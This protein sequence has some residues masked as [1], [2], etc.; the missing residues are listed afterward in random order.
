MQR[1]VYDINL[2]ELTFD[3]LRAEQPPHCNV[4]LKPH[5][6]T[7]LQRC[8]QYER[9]N[10][11]LSEFETM[12][13]NNIPHDDYIRTQIG[14]LGDRVGSGKSFV[15]LALLMSPE[16]VQTGSVIKSYGLNKVL[17]STRDI[18]KPVRTN[19]LVIPHNLC[20]QWEQYINR[21]SS[22]LSYLIIN[23]NA[24]LRQLHTLNY[25][26]YDLLVITGTQYNSAAQIIATKSIKVKRAIFDEVDSINI[27]SCHPIEASFY[28]FVT[29]S[30]GNLLYPRGHSR[31][32]TANGQTIMNATGLKNAGFIKNLFTDLNNNVSKDY[33]KVLVI[34][35]R[36]DFVMQSIQLEDAMSHEIMCK[37]PHAIRVLHGLVDKKIINCLNAGDVD[38]AISCINPHHRTT[39]DNIITLLVNK[40]T[41][42]VH[43]VD[44]KIQCAEITFFESEQERESHIATL[45]K[46]KTEL[47]SILRN[48]SE[49]VNNSDTCSICLNDIQNQTVVPCCSNSY[50][51]MCISVWLGQE[52]TMS[53][54]NRK[55]CCPICKSDLTVNDLLVVQ[56]GRENAVDATQDSN[57]R[58]EAPVDPTLPSTN[59]QNDKLTNME[60]LL[61][62]LRRSEE[63]RKILIFSMFDNS[64]AAIIHVLTRLQIS[65]SY[66]KGNQHHIQ[67]VVTNYKSCDLDVLLINPQNYGSG[68]NLENT[69]DIIMFHRFNTEID[70]QVIGRAHR[71][72]RTS[73][74]KVWYLLHDNEIAQ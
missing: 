59:D 70:K 47:Q 26:E 27:P 21:F 38:G 13:R 16:V 66:L 31:W 2:D 24:S 48:M 17:L 62:H 74:L 11:L 18:Q 34:R 15:I 44:A 56:P 39:Q 61:Q 50:C 6:L 69:T 73:Q 5:Q 67:N 51:F 1:S 12:R 65:W 45:L 54:R 14:I 40:Y 42:E 63:R 10:L 53:T 60:I 19:V 3:S 8:L 30:Y 49:R 33:I 57:A 55:M 72:G 22:Q 29:A 35:N 52:R 37:T 4:V 58:A 46:K 25:D 20:F 64:F 23:K 43:N 9:S 7:L 41:N 68:L 28:W 71:M 32:E 36:N